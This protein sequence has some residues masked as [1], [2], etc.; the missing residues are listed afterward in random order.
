[1]CASRILINGGFLY[2]IFE[3]NEPPTLPPAG[4]K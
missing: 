1:M 2:D 4:L 3:L